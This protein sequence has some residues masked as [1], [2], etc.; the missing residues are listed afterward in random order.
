MDWEK[1]LQDDNWLNFI[2]SDKW[3]Y[4][5]GRIGVI[6]ALYIV[7]VISWLDFFSKNMNELSDISSLL[8]NAQPKFY[9]SIAVLIISLIVCYV[10]RKRII[11]CISRCKEE[12]FSREELECLENRRQESDIVFPMFTAAITAIGS[13]VATVVGGQFSIIITLNIAIF[14]LSIS[15]IIFYP[16]REFYNG[17]IKAIENMKKDETN[18]NILESIWASSMQIREM[19]QEDYDI[20]NTMMFDS[21]NG[22]VEEG[23][24]V[25]RQVECTYNQKEHS[26]LIQDKNKI[27]LV[28]EINER[29]IGCSVIEKMQ[30]ENFGGVPMGIRN[31]DKFYLSPF[32]QKK[33]ADRCFFQ[34]IEEQ[35]VREGIQSLRIT[36][37]GFNKD[38]IAL[39]KEMGLKVEND[40]YVK[41]L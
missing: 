7:M 11:R 35:L 10:I 27:C 16:E 25:C 37:L 13:F 8:K 32:Y 4:K 20:I 5:L 9:C 39:Y 1:L 36:A 24:S 31:I 15:I 38:A 22:Q 6:I 26:D 14:V 29:I 33:G 2:I 21:C 18:K 41:D 12:K 17:L 40:L 3:I 34:L 23:L 19:V 28:A 30:V